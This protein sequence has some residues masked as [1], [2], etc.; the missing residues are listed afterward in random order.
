MSV[1]DAESL[2]K[3]SP[4]RCAAEGVQSNDFLDRR[5][6]QISF[7]NQRRV[8]FPIIFAPMAGLSHVAFRQLVRT[9]LPANAETLLF[10]EMLSTRLLPSEEVGE[11]PQT[12]I[13]E[14][15]EDLVP[16]LLG[17]DE[18]WIAPSIRKLMRL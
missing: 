17:N 12:K 9:Y 7:G 16:Q 14:G 4:I 18:S 13:A 10:T 8:N 11:T 5:L 2:K 15:E 3:V 6:S 1:L